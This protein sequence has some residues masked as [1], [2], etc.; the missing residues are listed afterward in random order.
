MVGETCLL[1]CTFGRQENPRAQ[2]Q[3]YF[4]SKPSLI[5]SYSIYSF[6]SSLHF[7][8]ASLSS[9]SHEPRIIRL[10][11]TIFSLFVQSLLVS[12]LVQRTLVSLLVERIFVF[13]LVQLTL[14][15]DLFLVTK[16]ARTL[17]QSNQQIFL[18][19]QIERLC[20][21]KTLFSQVCLHKLI[22]LGH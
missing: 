1:F 4:F 14:V 16:P 17:Y 13:L 8:A 15:S 7:L 11:L 3:E 2:L 5:S 22:T 21:H 20:L 19:S 12:L 10:L 6:Y 9:H 18:T